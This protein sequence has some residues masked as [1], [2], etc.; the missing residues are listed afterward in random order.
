MEVKF[1]VIDV[2]KD[3]LEKFKTL[4]SCIFLNITY[5][6]NF[7]DEALKYY[8]VNKIAVLKDTG[9]KVGVL[10]ASVILTEKEDIVLKWPWAVSS[11]GHGQ[12]GPVQN[13]QFSGKKSLYLSTL[14]CKILNRRQGIY[15]LYAIKKIFFSIFYQ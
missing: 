8:G 4:H 1:S 9:E 5:P 3:N 13:G 2:T 14:G 12:Y 7:F 15:W 11:R 10:S 6:R